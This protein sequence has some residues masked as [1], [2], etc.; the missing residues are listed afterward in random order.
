MATKNQN[1]TITLRNGH[2]FVDIS[3][4]AK[5]RSGEFYAWARSLS[6][7]QQIS[8]FNGNVFINIL[9]EK[10]DGSNYTYT[11]MV[12]SEVWHG[13]GISQL[14]QQSKSGNKSSI[15]ST[16]SL[17]RPS[18]LHN[19]HNVWDNKSSN[20]T[21]SW[22]DTVAAAN[23]EVRLGPEF[24]GKNVFSK[25][26]NGALSQKSQSPTKHNDQ[27]TEDMK[28]DEAD[29]PMGKPQY[30]ELLDSVDVIRVICSHHG[31]KVG[32]AYPKPPA[33]EEYKQLIFY[34]MHINPNDIEDL[35]PVRHGVQ[36]GAWLLNI[37]LNKNYDLKKSYGKCNGQ[38]KFG[39]DKITKTFTHRWDAEIEG[40]DP[41]KNIEKQKFKLKLSKE[42]GVKP[43]HILS[44]AKRVM[45]VVGRGIFKER[46]PKESGLV[47]GEGRGL[48][49][50]FYY[51][52]A[53]K[54]EGV[55]FP[56][57]LKVNDY[58]IRIWT[59]QRDEELENK[60]QADP[61]LR[62]NRRQDPDESR[63]P[64]K[65]PGSR[66]TRVPKPP[67]VLPDFM[68]DYAKMEE[69]TEQRKEEIR[70]QKE[71]EEKEKKEAA[72]A[73]G[74]NPEAE[75]DVVDENP[76]ETVNEKEG[77]NDGKSTTEKENNLV[78]PG[79]GENPTPKTS[80]P[81]D[82]SKL[83]TTLSA[84]D[85]ETKESTED[86]DDTKSVGS[87]NSQKR[88]RESSDSKD[89]ERN[90]KA[91]KFIQDCLNK[92]P[93]E[94]LVEKQKEIDDSAVDDGDDEHNV[95]KS[96]HLLDTNQLEA[97][98]GILNGTMYDDRVARF[99][100]ILEMKPNKISNRELIWLFKATDWRTDKGNE[101]KSVA[102]G[103]LLTYF[104]ALVLEKDKALKQLKEKAM[105]EADVDDNEEND[106]SGSSTD[107]KS[108]GGGIFNAIK[109]TV[110]L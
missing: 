10:E 16:R 14:F 106:D 4:S 45:K 51:F 8:E 104:K 36:A 32:Q 34:F 35:V 75:D 33:W 88:R 76:K 30:H 12:T 73:A 37:R 62:R 65:P 11:Q 90:A 2:R 25:F 43:H 55:V 29:E 103:R 22:A 44:A 84:I 78:T 70:I 52:F 110:G 105:A 42:I 5:G 86:D 85:E 66:G 97:V 108:G 31:Y 99:N 49:T 95:D 71:L 56:E 91:T 19:V 50:G 101:I 72:E 18:Q 26:G 7:D 92:L 89:D 94:V 41:E 69:E 79:K 96:L 1:K 82:G 23:A 60:I 47:D 27:E 21:S 57:F 61:T 24:G 67:T 109:S 68:P 20:E 3:S 93:P 100:S 98:D 64:L 107:T 17:S 59:P 83:E 58:R 13:K 77:T 15:N 54:E 6:K 81:E 48:G 102:R 28:K 63:N 39:V 38:F 40:F 46:Y 9:K 74:E 53:A 87:Q 80:T